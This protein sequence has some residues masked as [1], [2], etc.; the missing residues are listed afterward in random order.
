MKLHFSS[1][2]DSVT[3]ASYAPPSGLCHFRLPT[4]YLSRRVAIISYISQML[5]VGAHSH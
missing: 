2:T 3:D 4:K 1:P 5:M